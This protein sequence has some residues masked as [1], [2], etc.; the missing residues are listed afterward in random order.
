VSADL[1]VYLKV[2]NVTDETG[3]VALRPAGVRGPAP[4][5]LGVGVYYT[6]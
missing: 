6:F 1:R 4:R 3:A 5:A 2:D